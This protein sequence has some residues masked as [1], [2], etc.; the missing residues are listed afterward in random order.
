MNASFLGPVQVDG[1]TALKSTLNVTNNASFLGAVQVD[2]ATALKSSLIVTN[3]AS[4]LSAVQVDGPVRMNASMIV[5]RNASFLDVV[6]VDGPTLLKSTLNVSNNASFLSDVQIYGPTHLA[7]LNAS[8]NAS[9]LSAVQVD[10]PTLLKSSLNVSKNASFLDTVQIDGPTILNST[11]N[12]SGNATFN[13]VNVTS[14]LVNGLPVGS[15]GMGSNIY[16]NVYSIPDTTVNYVSSNVNRNTLLNV[17][18]IAPVSGFYQ[19]DAY[20]NLTTNTRTTWKTYLQTTNTSNV[21]CAYSSPFVKSSY[22]TQNITEVIKLNETERV[23][24]HVVCDS[25]V[26]LTT[27]GS[28]FRTT[29]VGVA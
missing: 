7:S 14:L 10:G 15:G 1:H 13:N 25:D 21:S 22:F 27:K 6:Q 26:S 16:W 28:K 5:L 18:Y 4:F 23:D 20:L 17:S 29:L 19:V 12:V 11:L 9:F 8:M 3:N 24:L 2:G